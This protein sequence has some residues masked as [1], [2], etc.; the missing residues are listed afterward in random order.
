MKDLKQFSA[1]VEDQVKKWSG[2]KQGQRPVW[3]V[4]SLSRD[5]GTGGG[6]IA[7]A[8]AERLHFAFWDQEL[9]QAIAENTGIGKNLL[10]SLDEHSRSTIEDL[11]SGVLL[12]RGGTEVEYVSQLYRIIHTIEKHGSGVIVGRGAQFVLKNESSLK[13]KIVADF[14]RRVSWVMQREKLDQK[15]AEKKVRKIDKDRSDFHL[16][17]YYKDANN[18]VYYDLIV[19]TEGLHHDN[20][21]NIIVQAFKEK[22]GTIPS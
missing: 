13:V 8:V 15:E 14:P 2:L 17:Y 5:Y 7:K 22:F 11:I 20:A 10:R 16:R 1:I 18:P 12:G 6:A 4:I 9:V 21:V 3:P 19:N